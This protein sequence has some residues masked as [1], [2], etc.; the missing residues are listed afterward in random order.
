MSGQAQRQLDEARAER[1]KSKFECA[2]RNAGGV[3]M[4]DL[5]NLSQCMVD[6]DVAA[7]G[8]ARRLRGKALVASISLEVVV[9]A[10]VLLWP[11]ATL[12]VLTPQLVLTPI[13]PYH[14]EQNSPPATHRPSEPPVSDRRNAAARFLFQPPRIPSHVADTADPE[15]PGID[16]NPDPFAQS[17][18]SVGIPG[19]NEIGREIEIARPEPKSKPRMVSL[20]LMDAS[21]VHRV[22][23]E[24]PRIATLTRLSGSVVLRAV[25][26][27][28][29]EVHEIE[30]LSGN[31]IL[32]DAARAA[33]RQWRYRPTLLNGQAVEVETQI[34]VNFVLD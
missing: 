23:P 19:G 3:F 18:P 12:G 1:R 30:V 4:S 9:I 33:V 24:Y 5:G 27:I 22:Q 16:T 14:G 25:I 34:T 29:G 10:G 15:P 13:P 11:L 26:G 6:S 28:D 31:P 2:Q 8:R 32:A 17:G 20:G 7:N 21:L